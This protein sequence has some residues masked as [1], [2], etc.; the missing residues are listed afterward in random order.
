MR[1]KVIV[2]REV[3]YF[4]ELEVEADNYRQAHNAAIKEASKYPGL[5]MW[6]PDIEPNEV[7]G[8]ELDVASITPMETESSKGF[9]KV[10]V[11]L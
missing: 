6:V 10:T 1:Y 8:F 11:Q 9:S 2:D 3:H 4:M 7:D 5:V